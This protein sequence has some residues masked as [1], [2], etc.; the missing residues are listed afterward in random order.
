MQRE[1]I[2]AG[3]GGQGLM[4]IGK[5]LALAGLEEGKEVTWLPSYGPEMRGGTANCTVVVSDKPIGSPLIPSPTGAIVMNRPSHDKFAPCLKKGGI[6]V[7]NSSLIPDRSDRTDIR[8]FRIKAN[9]IAMELGSGRSANLVVLGAYLG[10]D[11]IVSS[12]SIL[13]AIKKA[14]ARKKKFID[15]NCKTFMKGYEL[16]RAG[17]CDD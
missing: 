10:L 16:A 8:S 7:V 1:V 12:G 2:M 4:S 11:E 15:V 9:E 6:L 14:F 13:N 5:L 17:K 3:F